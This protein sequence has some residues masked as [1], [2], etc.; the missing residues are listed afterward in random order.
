MLGVTIG[1]LI[2]A[3]VASGIVVIALTYT[4]GGSTMWSYIYGQ[5]GNPVSGW[6]TAAPLMDG[7]SQAQPTRPLWILIGGIFCLFLGGMRRLYVWW[8]FHPLGAALSITWIMVIFW[9]PALIAWALKGLITRYGGVRAYL[10]L[11]PLFLGFIFGEF[12]AA[13]CWT[14]ISFVFKTNPPSFPWS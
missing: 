2:Y 3:I 6:Y 5:Y 8:P 11:R 1:T 10:N 4:R 14:I 12:F 7:I 9:F 13:V